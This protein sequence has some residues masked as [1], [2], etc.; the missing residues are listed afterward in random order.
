MPTAYVRKMA[1]KKGKPVAEI[2]KIWDK[3]KERA[4]E[5]GHGEE[6]DY[7]TGIFQNMLG[8]GYSVSIEQEIITE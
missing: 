1:E 3:A 4:A 8:E 7:I 6:Y 5:E 2:E